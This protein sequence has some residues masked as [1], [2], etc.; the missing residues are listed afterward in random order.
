MSLRKLPLL[1]LIA[2]SAPAQRRGA[3][4]ARPAPVTITSNSQITMNGEA[5]PLTNATG[6]WYVTAND[7]HASITLKTVPPK[8]AV[9]LDVAWF[10]KGATHR[11]DESNN[12]DQTGDH[13]SFLLTA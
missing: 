2:I 8:P 13:V 7:A 3:A 4:P 5:I 6:D 12:T 10:G 9:T 1:C 11:I